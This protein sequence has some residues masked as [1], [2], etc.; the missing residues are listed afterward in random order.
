MGDFPALLSPTHP[1]NC[2]PRCSSPPML[3][4]PALACALLLLL[5]AGKGGAV[6]GSTS[7]I[8][9]D[10]ADSGPNTLRG[11]LQNATSGDGIFFS[12]SFPAAL[13]LV[14]PLDTPPGVSL[15]GPGAMMYSISG[16]NSMRIFN[17]AQTGSATT[18]FSGMT[19]A[20]GSSGSYGGCIFSN[21]SSVVVTDMYFVGCNAPEGAAIYSANSGSASVAG[22]TF[23]SCLATAGSILTFSASQAL[24]ITESTL[25]GNNATGSLFNSGTLSQS[26]TT[27]TFNKFTT[28]NAGTAAVDN[29]IVSGN[30][31]GSYSISDN[32]YNMVSSNVVLTN[33]KIPSLV[34]DS[35]G[36]LALADNG[37]K[38]PTCALLPSSPGF[39]EGTSDPTDS[40]DQ[41]GQGFMRYQGS[42][43]DIGSYEVQYPMASA[44][45]S[46]EVFYAGEL[47]DFVIEVENPTAVDI[48]GAVLSVTITDANVTF[49]NVSQNSGPTLALDSYPFIL[50][51]VTLPAASV[52]QLDFFV[53][54]SPSYS[55]Y[56]FSVDLYLS[57]TIPDD[58]TGTAANSSF[59]GYAHFVSAQADLSIDMDGPLDAA[60]GQQLVYNITITNLG[61]SNAQGGNFTDTTPEGFTFV[62][63]SQSLIG[64]A[65]NMTLD[66]PNVGGQ[67][68]ITGT[69]PT[70][71]PGDAIVLTLVLYWPSD[72]PAETFNNSASVVI[73]G[74]TSDRDSSNDFAYIVTDGVPSAHLAVGISGPSNIQT[75]DTNVSYTV[76]VTNF[77]PSDA[78]GVVISVP[79]PAYLFF[80]SVKP[81][82]NLSAPAAGSNDTLSGSLSDMPPGT[83]LVFTVV[84]SVAQMGQSSLLFNVSVDSDT[85]NPQ[86][87]DEDASLVSTVGATPSPSPSPT[88][89]SP[90]TPSPTASGSPSPSPSN[91]AGTLSPTSTATSPSGTPSPSTPVPTPVTTLA[92]TLPGST[93]TAP[94][95]TPS[96]SKRAERKRGLIEMRQ[97][98]N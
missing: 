94:P 22:S 42:A 14:S 45:I 75:T 46:E 83:S 62:A 90:P 58:S 7:W 15:N 91:T 67:G 21:T 70:L 82:A 92:T 27:I 49:V 69:F 61:P 60:P 9:T 55:G 12:L 59:D 33:Q 44:S 39:N 86:A 84:Y 47:Y 25:Y 43:S 31:A 65:P 78:E 96:P 51:N 97:A 53:M 76:N 28:L 11:A 8:V 29:S 48:P 79:T 93:T 38:T 50:N 6:A 89:T 2:V 32:G 3:A 5:A 4:S 87:A 54:L 74:S 66:T 20:Y 95:T 73:T 10:P 1:T 37:G 41:R 13:T 34:S 72:A 19:L 57:A 68:N 16:N 18:S 24:T 63:I 30:T 71:H 36:L 52:I 64:G 17:V 40:Y 98:G 23:D 85:L 81:S 35:P 88:A 26:T 56:F 77:G 80:I